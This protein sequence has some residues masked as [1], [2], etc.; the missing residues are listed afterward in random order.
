MDDEL[1]GMIFDIQ[2]FCI[3]DGPGIRT[4]V[5]MKGCPLRCLWCS[6]PESQNTRQEFMYSPQRCIGCG[7]CGAVCP[8]HT[9]FSSDLYQVENCLQCGK[10]SAVCPTEALV[11]KGAVMSISELMDILERDHNVYET[12]GGGVT[13]S[14]GEP[15]MQPAFLKAALGA[16]RSAGIHTCIE[17]T[18]CA[19]W[20]V[21]EACLPQLDYMFCDIKETIPGK[22]KA[23]T[24]V[25]NE[26]ILENAVKAASLTDALT[27]RIPVIPG[28]NTSPQ[29]REGFC[30]FFSSV[31]TH[32]V[33]LLPYHNFGES[34]Y[35]LL[36]RAYPGTGISA[37]DAL[38]EA[39]KL[40][41]DLRDA[42][43]QVLL[44]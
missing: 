14:G 35:H 44:E 15:F 5:F 40:A 42:G 27:F 18:M 3:H 22:H 28:L 41:S 17:T 34:K 6:N 16:C 39:Q 7:E 43:I 25:S 4:T 23:W 8:L 10:C 37:D 21:I 2:R 31:P 1:K 32:P 26:R 38:S 12:S 30:R 19:P 13:F 24:G 20:E 11:Q 36:K 33:E 29:S 9:P